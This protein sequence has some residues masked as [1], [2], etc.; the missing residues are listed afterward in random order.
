MDAKRNTKWLLVAASLLWSVLAVTSAL[1]A[2]FVPMMFDSAEAFTN[3]PWVLMALCI[4]TFPL[5]CIGTVIA[6][7]WAFARDKIRMARTLTL[8]PV[9]NL[10]VGGAATVW[11]ELARDL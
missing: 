5:V 1:P 2:M 7:W 4:G 8:L 6:S 9:F 11:T 3:V 10:V